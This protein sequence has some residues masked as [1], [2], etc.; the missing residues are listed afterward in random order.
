MARGASCGA[1]GSNFDS[2]DH[3]ISD[4]SSVKPELLLGIKA[5]A[6]RSKR[7]GR[8]CLA[9]TKLGGC[10]RVTDSGA[11]GRELGAKWCLFGLE[12]TAV[13]SGHT[14]APR[15]SRAAPGAQAAPPE[16][17]EGKGC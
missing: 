5:R 15:R 7:I 16:G 4:S 8:M 12:G 3:A 6:D 2:A 11:E 13:E 10:R 17:D 9:T 1:V 14:C